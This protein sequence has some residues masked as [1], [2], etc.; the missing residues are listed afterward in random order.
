M[1]A[2][3][4]SSLALVRMLHTSIQH[5]TTGRALLHVTHC[6]SRIEVRA[7]S[8]RQYRKALDMLGAAWSVTRVTDTDKQGS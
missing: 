2:Q 1:N 4:L 8:V 6:G 3:P 5:K 7:Y